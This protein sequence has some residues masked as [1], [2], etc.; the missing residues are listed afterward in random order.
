M[1]KFKKIKTK[2]EGLY[3]IEPTVFGD[4]RGFFL[5]SYQYEE[6]KELGIPN[7]F[8]QDNHSKSMKGVLRG[9]HFQKG[10]FAQ[11]KLV[12]VFKGAVLDIA[13]DL[14]PNSKTFGKYE[15]V[16]LNEENKKM[17]FIPRG[18]GH[19]FLTL[20]E[21]TEFFYKCDNQYA[22]EF[23][24][25]ILWNDDELAIDWKLEEYGFQKENIILSEKDKKNQSFAE[26]KKAQQ[27]ENILILGSKGQLGTEFCKL[28]DKLSIPYIPTDKLELD[29]TNKDLIEKFLENKRIT[30]IINCAAYNDVDKAEEER[31]ACECL[32]SNTIEI[33]TSVAKDRNIYFVTYSTDFV[34]DGSKKMPYTEQDLASPLSY[35][36]NSKR[37][38][39]L[40]ALHY[41][42]GLVIRTSWVYGIANNNFCKQVIEWSKKKEE[43]RIV[44]DQ[45]SSPTSAKDLALFSWLL[46]QKRKYGLYHFSNDG[47]ASKYDQAK[48]ILDYIGWEGELYRANSSEFL[49]KAKRPEYSKLQSKKIEEAVGMRI[50]DWRISM[51]EFLE[52][53]KDLWKK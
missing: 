38:G 26:Y 17:F 25:G 19:G 32:N 7:H 18:F 31:N 10:E 29:I 20:E 47:E 2:I 48:F 44:G 3:I 1:S 50:P 35:Y 45:I 51:I 4:N 16:L 24:S 11:A 9:I 52:E 37:K 36:G 21:E 30:H 13:V 14:R 39:E 42:K 40:F 22:P 5:E 27:E 12:R 41:E 49:L 6:F 34:F 43:L 8:I 53:V 33:L 15:A 23:E 28:F 46:I